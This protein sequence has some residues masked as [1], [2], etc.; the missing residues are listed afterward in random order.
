MARG[1]DITPHSASQNDDLVACI[2]ELARHFGVAAPDSVFSSLALNA[3]G[4]LPSHQVDGALDLI[5][6]TGRISTGKKLPTDDRTFPAI[7][8]NASDGYSIA[9]EI[10]GE[11][12]K[13]WHPGQAEADWVSVDEV[14]DDYADWAVTVLPD[15]TRLRQS[16]RP[17]DE[18]P[19]Q[20]WFWSEI[21]KIRPQF[22]PVL[23][24]SFFIN[25]LAFALPLF[26]MNVYDRII[27]NKAVSSLWVLAIG[28]VLAFATEFALRLARTG[29]LDTLGRKLDIT[30]SQKI[31]GKILN[32]PLDKKAGTT[33]SLVARVNEYQN[34]RDFFTAT[35]V[36]LIVDMAFL[37]LFLLLIA[38]IAGWLALIPL[39]AITLMV[40]AGYVLERRMATAATEAQADQSLQQNMLVESISGIETLKA[41]AG[42]GQM[43]GR[44]RILALMA[45]GTQERLKHV[46]SIAV[47]LASSFQ[48][49]TS[50]SLVIGGY[51]LFERGD[52]SMGAIIAI[53]M[54]AGRSLM[55]AS[56]LAFLLTRGKQAMQT[57]DSIQNLMDASDERA[58]GGSSIVP[59]V[60][61]GTVSV[62]N[63]SFAYPQTSVNALDDINLS[64]RPGERIAIIGRV[65]SGKSTLGRLLC[66]L[67][68]P[69]EGAILVDD[70]DSRQ[71][72]PRELR[73]ALRFVGQDAELFS[74]SV[75]ENLQLGSPK[76]SDEEL[77]DAMRKV[78]ADRFL[79]RDASGFDR[80]IGE[81]GGRL[82]GGQRSFLVLA[83]AFVTPSKLLFLDEPT[84]A[85]DAQTERS[86]IEFLNSALSPEQTLIV[87]THRHA[88]L[89]LCDRLIV[90]D[91]GRIIADGPRAEVMAKAAQAGA[92]SQDEQ[93]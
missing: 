2:K 58:T 8:R 76:A 37:F 87:S 70:V 89:G 42:E 5:G 41:C 22:Y 20:H 47:G 77:L 11:S 38:Y 63:L 15:A 71:Y 59:T 53:V 19:Q 93:P 17:W 62:Q 48:Q 23:I 91:N 83:R 16:E 92:A 26:T 74:G 25:L 12:M 79:A 27:P 13:R 32:T 21:Q 65:A 80:M 4:S 24:A 30:L 55:P 90:M 78:G 34:V 61:S 88:I 54:L 7:I 44:W 49:I 9:Y 73:T 85:M 67:Y 31:F 45:S 35:T 6:L 29:L 39:L 50:I 82:S 10:S 14:A 75:K 43:L 86:F 33:G 3:D 66:G 60:R 36:V 52:I 72:H 51:Y 84:G 46:S 18:A 81:R 28:V 64:I 40:I 69:G 68:P 57:M 56:Q 1:A